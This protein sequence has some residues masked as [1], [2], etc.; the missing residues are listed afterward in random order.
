MDTQVIIALISLA[1]MVISA[2]I[3]AVVSNKLIEH[4][5]KALEKKVDEHNGY[6]KM[7]AESHETTALM[8]KDIQYIKEKLQ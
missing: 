1:G 6:A 2:I 4:R 7:F 5:L 8:Q 3:S